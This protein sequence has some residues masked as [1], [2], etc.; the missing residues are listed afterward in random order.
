MRLFGNY[1]KGGE[2][3]L[4]F[5]PQ[6]LWIGVFWKRTTKWRVDLWLCLIPMVP[7]HIAWWWQP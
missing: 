4:E 3:F 2:V 7:L 5:K 1:H 6:D